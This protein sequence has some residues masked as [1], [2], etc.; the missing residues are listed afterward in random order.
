MGIPLREEKTYMQ[1]MSP[2]EYLA[3]DA[4][5]LHDFTTDGKCSQCGECCKD[6][7]PVDFAEMDRIEK[8]IKSHH[9]KEQDHHVP[10]ST[11]DML[12]PFLNVDTKQCVIY[13]VRP[14]VCRKFLCSMTDAEVE[15]L[16]EERKTIGNIISMRTQ[17]FD[18][19][20]SIYLAAQA[21]RAIPDAKLFLGEKKR[22]FRKTFP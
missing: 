22:P 15:K 2:A 21:F 3:E 13:P 8:Y 5:G 14:K 10:A 19:P 18:D 11:I 20:S 17:F 4:K 1:T 9:I 16:Q 7:L 12:C 6:I